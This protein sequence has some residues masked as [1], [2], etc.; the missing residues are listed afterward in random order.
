MSSPMKFEDP[1]FDK[2][3][4]YHMENLVQSFKSA[5]HN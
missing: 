3:I 5:K 4:Q 2:K 1:K